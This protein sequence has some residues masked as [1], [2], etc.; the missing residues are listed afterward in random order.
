MALAHREQ[1]PC[2]RT[3]V[4]A[5]EIGHFVGYQNDETT[6]ASFSYWAAEDGCDGDGKPQGKHGNVI[7]EYQSAAV[8][9]GFADF[10]AAWLWNRKTEYDC[11]FERSYASDFDLNGSDDSDVYSC[12]GKPVSTLPGWVSSHDW[13][14]D[15]IVQ[16]A[17]S[18]SGTLSNRGTQ[19][20]WLRFFWD[21]LTDE[22]VPPADIAGLYDEMDPK[23][24][25]ATGSTPLGSDDPVQR[26]TT[27]CA[28]MS[29]S[30]ECAAQDYN[31]QD[32]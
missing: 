1:S 2:Q 8:V 9:E 30:S 28:A 14:E 32:H 17:G 31:G 12:E 6:G 18:C 22:S 16:G 27:A 25:D 13:L 29:L 19:Y 7:K 3:V 21:M 10:F 20:D 4:I 11:D 15:A 24:F 23:T 5:H 26:L